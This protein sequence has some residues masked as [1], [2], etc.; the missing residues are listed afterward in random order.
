MNDTFTK[1][2]IGKRFLT[3]DGYTYTAREE[4]VVVEISPSNLRVKLRYSNGVEWW[5][6]NDGWSHR[7][8]EELP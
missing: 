4:V 2:D 5:A 8:L 6:A 7:K 1:D 3:T